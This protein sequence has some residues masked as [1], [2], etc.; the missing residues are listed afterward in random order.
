MKLKF[1][2]QRQNV[3]GQNVLGWKQL[4]PSRKRR[5]YTVEA[6]CLIELG[7]EV[8]HCWVMV[9]EVNLQ[10]EEGSG[11]CPTGT[12]TRFS[13]FWSSQW[14]Q[15]IQRKTVWG[16]SGANQAF[17][18]FTYLLLLTQGHRKEIHERTTLQGKSWWI[19]RRKT[20]LMPSGLFCILGLPLQLTACS[21][22]SEMR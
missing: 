15:C 8:P 1:L 6:E 13:A 4:R 22:K 7:H 5:P 18:I 21:K 11:L 20:S 10:I 16:N 2:F 14:A 9:Y 12:W 19:R 17:L 3:L